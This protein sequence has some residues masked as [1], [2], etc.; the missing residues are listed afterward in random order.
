MNAPLIVIFGV[1][2]FRMHAL[3]GSEKL[4]F[5]GG[6]A[7]VV[8]TFFCVTAVPSL[9][10]FYEQLRAAWAAVFMAHFWILVNHKKSPLRSFVQNFSSLSDTQWTALRI[11]WGIC[12]LI[13]SQIMVFIGMSESQD[14]SLYLAP[15][16]FGG[17]SVAAHLY[18]V[19]KNPLYIVLAVLEFLV[20]LHADFLIESYLPAEKVIWII[21]LLWTLLLIIQVI[22]PD[23]IKAKVIG[24]VVLWLAILVYAHVIYHGPSSKVGLMAVV[25]M[26]ML[27]SLTP[28]GK[29]GLRSSETKLIGAIY[30]ALP[31]YLSY[32]IV[33][34]KSDS[35]IQRLQLT[36]LPPSVFTL[37]CT[38]VAVYLLKIS[39]KNMRVEISGME[40][41]LLSLLTNWV[42]AEFVSIFKVILW[43]SS[44]GAMAS[45]IIFRE[46]A[47]VNR[48]F[49]MM[50]FLTGGLAAAWYRYGKECK[51][52][53]SS[54]LMII[55]SLMFLAAIRHQTV[56]LSDF[57][58]NEYDV[59]MCLIISLFISSS[60]QW[61]EH[62]ERYLRL[63]ILFMLFV[64]PTVALGWSHYHQMGTNYTL[65][66]IGMNSLLFTFLGKDD[67]ESPYN[68]V[69][70]SGFVAFSIIALWTKLEIHSFHVHV[71]P[72]GMGVLVLLQL[73]Q[74]KIEAETRQRIRFVTLLAMVST[75]GY[76]A[77][78]AEPRS[79]GFNITMI[80]LCLV[81]MILGTALKIRLYLSIGF[82][83]L[84]VNLTSILVRAVAEMNKGA[85]MAIMGG[86]ILAIGSTLVFGNLYYKT[87]QEKIRLLIEKWKDKLKLWE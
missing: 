46:V 57:W 68:M 49:G 36:P 37:F 71:I 59:W 55:S 73:F 69:A 27:G 75:A 48:D 41:R 16:L 42:R 35:I 18:A 52:M 26:A 54:I 66:I 39:S 19:R 15:L 3:G 25:L 45:M 77:L 31:T 2:L 76:Y 53:Y 72:T 13:A 32:F 20:A 11:P 14:K 22:R 86:L 83:G 30:L 74:D 7:L 51:A 82:A 47:F 6:L 61:I 1:L 67:K 62:S 23:K 58:R 8:G 70:V 60:K 78:I 56:M 33:L 81:S 29:L 12:L 50:L 44:I 43:L 85:R 80:I 84:L 63:P 21:L 9:S 24:G 34:D 17:A 4:A 38:G 79:I 28:Y 10:P 87:H 65:G 5:Y 64:L 40:Y